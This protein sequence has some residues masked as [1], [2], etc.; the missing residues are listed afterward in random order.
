MARKLSD[1]MPLERQVVAAIDILRSAAWF[2]HVR[3]Y[4]QKNVDRKYETPYAIGKF[5]QP[6]TY[7]GVSPGFYNHNMWP[8]YAAGL[9]CPGQ[10]TLA[11]VEKVV[12]GATAIYDASVWAMLNI[13]NPVGDQIDAGLRTLQVGVQESLYVR[14]LLGFDRYQRRKVGQGMLSSLEGHAI[15]LDSLAAA[16]LLLKEACEA[17]DSKQRFRVGLSLHRIL[18]MTCVSTP[19]LSY[20]LPL[21]AYFS[22]FVF[23]LASSD[24]LVIDVPINE[25]YEMTSLL[26]AYVAILEDHGVIRGENAGPTRERRRMLAGDLGMDMQFGFMPR[27]KVAPGCQDPRAAGHVASQTIGKD[28]GLSVLRRYGYVDFPP[29]SIQLDMKTAYDKAISAAPPETVHKSCR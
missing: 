21:I 9:H 16:V 12:P 24:S 27:L 20:R 1:S 4:L 29:E 8:K 22:L 15:G 10:A 2:E 11:A 23:P 14:K 17:G 3:E 6:E 5:I 28:W 25:F 18:L 26:S 19:V 13:V 7:G